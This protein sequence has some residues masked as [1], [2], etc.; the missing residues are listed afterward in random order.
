LKTIIDTASNY[1]YLIDN[2]L[3][4]TRKVRLTQLSQTIPK[5]EQLALFECE[6]ALSSIKIQ[7]RQ[8]DYQAEN[9]FIGRALA[10]YGGVYNLAET[11]N[12]SLR[13]EFTNPVLNKLMITFIGGLRRLVIN[14]QGRYIET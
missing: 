13:V 14:N 10:R 9:F 11:G 2:K 7:P 3:Q 12:A 6:K 8:L 5:T 4:P 1:N